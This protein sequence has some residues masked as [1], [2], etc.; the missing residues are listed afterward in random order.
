MFPTSKMSIQCRDKHHFLTDFCRL[1]HNKDFR[2]FK[3]NYMKDWSD[4]ETVFMYIYVY[5]YIAAEFRTRFGKDIMDDQM[6]NILRLVFTNVDLTR[7]VV[8][9][10]RNFQNHQLK[11]DMP[12][13]P[14]FLFK[15]ALT[16]EK[17]I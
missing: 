11:G 12:S 16:N 5:D 15:P 6:A 17:N 3:E 4:V 8:Q 10:F 13:L 2:T 9:I 7:S 1:M 14:S